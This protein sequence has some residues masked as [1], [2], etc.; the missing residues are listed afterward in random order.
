MLVWVPSRTR[1]KSSWDCT[2]QGS[3]KE[4]THRHGVTLTGCKLWK[5]Q[6]S[7]VQ[8]VSIEAGKVLEASRWLQSITVHYSWRE[9]GVLLLSMSLLITV[10]IIDN[11]VDMRISS[12]SCGLWPLSLYQIWTYL[13]SVCLA[14]VQ[15]I[16]GSRSVHSRQNQEEEG[17][18][19]EERGQQQCRARSCCISVNIHINNHSCVCIF[20]HC[21]WSWTTTSQHFFFPSLSLAISIMSSDFDYVWNQTLNIFTYF[22]YIFI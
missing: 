21:Q 15:K 4:S 16:W 22:F 10:W 11:C 12:G 17:A 19:Q 3:W 13:N 5:L 9:E 14:G 7:H 8:K 6:Q 20:V 1:F 2:T 18:E